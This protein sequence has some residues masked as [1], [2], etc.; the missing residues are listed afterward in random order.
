MA[1]DVFAFSGRSGSRTRGGSGL[2]LLALAAVAGCSGSGGTATQPIVPGGSVPTPTVAPSKAPTPTPSSPAS[3]APSSCT[4]PTT[5]T[6]GATGGTITASATGG[7]FTETVAAGQLA[8]STTVSLGYIASTALPAP[9][10]HAMHKTTDGRVS[11]MFTA[12]AGN[13]YVLALCTSF[14]GLT[15]TSGISLTGTG[16]VP[17]T[18]ALGSQLNIAIN[19][20]N[21][22]VDVGT[23]QVTATGNFQST[24]PT[25]TLP[26]I[27]QAGTYLV[28]VPPAS[29]TTQINLGFALFADDGTAGIGV[30]GLQFAQIENTSGVAL[31]TPTTQFFP[32]SGGDLDGQSLTPDA[33]R[34]AVVDGSNLVHFFSGIP[35]HTVVVASG[36]VDVTNYG[37]D[38]DSIASLP[39]GDQ[40]V[41]S[42]DEGGDLAVIS[43]ILAGT[44]AV[45]DTIPN[46]GNFRDGLAISNDG[47]VLLSR[48]Y[49]GIDV[50][51]ATPA[52]AHAGSGCN[53]ACTGTTS[54]NFSLVKTLASG[55]TGSVSTPFF[56]DGRDGMA[57]SPSD[58]SRALVVGLTPTDT[59]TIQLLTG[60]NTSSPTVSSTLALHVPRVARL[61]GNATEA[62]EPSGHRRPFAIT[63]SVGTELFAVA[64]TPDGTTGYVS[65]DA[66]IIT[67][68]GI[69]TGTL[70][71]VGS[72][73]SPTLT[74]QGA[75]C[76]LTGAQTIGI[77][78]DGK[79]LVAVD[80]LSCAVA[81]GTT[82]TTQGPGVLV[83]IPIGSGN[84][85]GA[86]VG[87]LIQ[88]VAPSNDQ[89]ITH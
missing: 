27:N 68:S 18:V 4:S 60:L 80:K 8:S 10:L 64:I 77:L 74:V 19:Q 1:R 50:F 58:A 2:A 36:T 26:G 85:L 81:I 17:S 15:P 30:N 78:P 72:V 14:G 83:T 41:V 59:P 23:A 51:K 24:V 53:P 3:S 43:G 32:I 42:A 9:L 22:W 73:Y 70:A 5:A 12:G 69:N 47:S 39:G 28:Y 48:G 86:P 57:I 67:I 38:G 46:N 29:N 62:P 82:N 84:A 65:T 61:L 44:P 63:P 52:A 20:N 54:F 71:Q 79:Y 45:A 21:T 56:E 35:Q 6:I 76:P 25:L 88:V 49:S 87:Q 89:M 7:T 33:S 55:T 75:T 11:P 31:A 13:T 16:V 34:G 66:G 40:V 37:S